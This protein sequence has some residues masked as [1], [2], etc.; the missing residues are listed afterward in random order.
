MEAIGLLAA[1]LVT[2]LLGTTILIRN[3]VRDFINDNLGDD[4][5]MH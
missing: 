2:L 5:W 4:P 3:H 1:V